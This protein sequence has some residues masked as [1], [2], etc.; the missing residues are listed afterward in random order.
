MD[1]RQYIIVCLIFISLMFKDVEN[2]FMCLL[3]ICIFSLENYLIISFVNFWICFW[4]L[5]VH[6]ISWIKILYHACVLRH[7]SCV[8]FFVTLWT[9]AHQ[10]PLSMGFSHSTGHLFTLLIFFWCRILKFFIKSSLST[11]SFV[12]CASDVTFKQPLPLVSYLRNHCQIQPWSFST[13]CFLLVI[14]LFL[15]LRFLIHC[16][17][18]FV[19]SVR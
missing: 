2:L 10:A 6:Y 1:M 15:T 9:V 12:A 19:Y 7:V 17:L 3:S 4:V 16:E 13:L 8:C 14:V 5:G 18:I 11:F